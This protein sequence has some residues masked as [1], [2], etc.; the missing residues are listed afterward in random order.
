MLLDNFPPAE[1]IAAAPDA[2]ALAL[3]EHVSAPHPLASAL[4]E[5]PLSGLAE[6]CSRLAQRPGTPVRAQYYTTHHFDT[7]FAAGVQALVTRRFTAQ[8]EHRRFCGELV[9]RDYKPADFPEFDMPDELSVTGELNEFGYQFVGEENS[10]KVI[11]RLEN[12]RLNTFGRLLYISRQMVKNDDIGLVANIIG[13]LGNAGARTEAR[14]LYQGLNL[15]PVMLDGERVFVPGKNIID[16]PLD[17]TN[18]SAG[19]TMMRRFQTPVGNPA[20]LSA[21]HLV[22]AA[23]LEL[24]ALKLTHQ[25]GL[26]ITVTATPLLP[27]QRW[28]LF[29]DPEQHAAC[30][31]LKLAGSTTAVMIERAT[32]FKDDSHVLR[33]RADLGARIMG[34]MGAVRGG[35]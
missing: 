16:G 13:G 10:E 29:S 14:L 22:V 25:L 23:E 17:E 24:P 19:M 15:N 21:R 7:A 5:R 6:A 34:R 32:S 31:T 35:E 8:A 33:A 18:L 30:V 20:D 3:G 2:L 11:E 1:I 12:V 9:L 4:A 26:N 27:A 28:F